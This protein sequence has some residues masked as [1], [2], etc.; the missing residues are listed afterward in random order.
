[1]DAEAVVKPCTVAIYTRTSAVV[2]RR[3]F[4]RTSYDIRR[5]VNQRTMM[6]RMWVTAIR[7]RTA[8][9]QETR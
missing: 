1:M 9:E 5:Q 8:M 3:F 6:I 7:M 2:Y 4:D